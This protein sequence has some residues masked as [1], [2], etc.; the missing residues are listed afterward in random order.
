MKLLIAFAALLLATHQELYAQQLKIAVFEVNATPPLGSPVAYAEARSVTDSLSARG[1]V[2]ITD[3]LPVVF[4]V[5][6]WI[7]ISNEGHDVWRNQL[8]A[9]AGTTIDRVSVHALHQHDGQDVI[10]Y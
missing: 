9:A 6:D 1:I 10:T 3:S 5:V 4:C 7:G 8:A 2:F